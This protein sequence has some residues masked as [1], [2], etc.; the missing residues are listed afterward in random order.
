MTPHSTS[1][2]DGK[3][4]PVTC[5][6]EEVI[7]QGIQKHLVPLCFSEAERTYFRAT[8]EG[9]KAAWGTIGTDLLSAAVSGW[10]FPHSRLHR[11]PSLL[12]NSRQLDDLNGG[13]WTFSFFRVQLARHRFQS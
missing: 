12:V 1:C 6:R 3:D 5:T 9:L 7:E 2:F 10:T 11:D 4:C 8:L 13:L